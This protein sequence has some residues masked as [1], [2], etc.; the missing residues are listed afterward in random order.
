MAMMMTGRVLLV[1]ALCVLWCVAGGVYARDVDTNALGG[2]MASGVLGENGSHMPDGCNKT[3]I[4]VPLRSVLPITAIEASTG[5]GDALAP[6]NNSNSSETSDAGGSGSGSTAGPA[7]PAAAGGGG[8]GTSTGGQGTGGIPS[9]SAGPPPPATPAPP[10][11]P[12]AAL[13]AGAPAAGSGDGEAG[14][15]GSNSSNTAGDSQTGVQTPA[16]A[17]AHNSTPAEGPTRTTSGTGH[18]GQEEEEEEEE[19]E[20]EKQQQSGEAQVQQQQQ[21]EHPAESGEE[22]AKDK[23]A[24]RT[25]ATANT[26][27]SD[28]S[29]AVSHATSPLLPLLLVVVCAAAVVA[30]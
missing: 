6:K 20:N 14:S 29:T 30:A 1:C 18:K 16:A 17:A 26:G 2:C 22:S 15:P 23:N 5:K 8:S 19:E 3:A 24:L 13:G 11:G 7:G 10:S 28:G 27:D 4:T 9:G 25:N 12:P 21:H